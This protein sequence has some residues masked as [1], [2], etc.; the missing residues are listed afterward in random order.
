MMMVIIAEDVRE[1]FSKFGPVLDCTLKT[2]PMTG[3]SRGF[4]FVLFEEPSAVE[5]VTL[6]ICSCHA[7]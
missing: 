3:K 7:N 2:D 6:T 4:G 1:Y 5:K